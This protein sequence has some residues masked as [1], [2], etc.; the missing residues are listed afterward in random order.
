MWWVKLFTYCI[1][2]SKPYGF[3]NPDYKIKLVHATV[4]DSELNSFTNGLSAE[5]LQIRIN[6][7]NVLI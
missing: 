4:A 6:S 1:D 3:E 7:L 5:S 2:V